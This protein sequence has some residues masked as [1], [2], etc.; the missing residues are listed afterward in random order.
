MGLRMGRRDFFGAGFESLQ[1][2]RHVASQF[3]LLAERGCVQSVVVGRVVTKTWTSPVYVVRAM[4]RALGNSLRMPMIALIPFSVGI[5]R[6]I[7]VTSGRCN[8]SFSIASRPLQASATS[9]MS[10]SA[11][12]SAAI[13]SRRR[14]WSSTV[15]TRIT[16]CPRLQSRITQTE[17]CATN[18]SRLPA[19]QPDSM[20]ITSVR[21]SNGGEYGQLNSVPAP[22]SLQKS[23]RG[24]ICFVRSRIPRNPQCPARPPPCRTFGSM[25][26]PSSQIR[27]RSRTESYGH[28]GFDPVCIG[29]PESVS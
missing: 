13:P 11:L 6:S 14:A 9:F 7:N 23:R 25:P 4:I 5:W 2:A 27:K 22:A 18:L 3:C 29:M 10:V 26:F 19:E 28:L 24:S 12:T 15:R 1:T 20:T 21:V 17:V 8:R 16:R